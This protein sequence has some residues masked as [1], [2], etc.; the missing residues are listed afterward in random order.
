MFDYQ[1]YLQFSK[2]HLL[3]A[4]WCVLFIANSEPELFIYCKSDEVLESLEHE[5][6]SAS[7]MNEK[8]RIGTD[9]LSQ[10]IC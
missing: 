1:P 10:D 9:Y 3:D 5:C 8:S 6:S 2:V 7:R 4:V